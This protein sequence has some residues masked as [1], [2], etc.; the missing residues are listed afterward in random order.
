MCKFSDL[1][2]KLL[3]SI[4]KSEDS[5]GEKIIFTTVDGEKYK[6]SHSQE[7]C[8]RIHIED[9]C[10]NLDD[11]IDSE[12]LMAEEITNKENEIP[13]EIKTEYLENYFDSYFLWT[14]YKLATIKGY[15]TIR[16]LGESNGY[17][18][19]GVD[20]EKIN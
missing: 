2:G 20:F 8:E 3:R 1:K 6:L 5:N 4:E 10:G 9:I 16:W 7:C 11:L 18:S 15:V 14:F 13:D 12:I 17:Y 19:V